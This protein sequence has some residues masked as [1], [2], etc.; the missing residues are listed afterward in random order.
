[1][2]ALERIGRIHGLTQEMKQ[3]YERKDYGGMVTV[4][5]RI[6]HHLT[7][8]TEVSAEL[9]EVSSKAADRLVTT[10]PPVRQSQQTVRKSTHYTGKREHRYSIAY[11]VREQVKH[12]QAGDVMLLPWP[13]DSLETRERFAGMVSAALINFWGRGVATTNSRAE[14]IEVMKNS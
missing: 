6:K 1:M 14:G 8:L 12:M 5:D 2:K 9:A 10:M 7:I 3:A 13:D 4:A 11:R